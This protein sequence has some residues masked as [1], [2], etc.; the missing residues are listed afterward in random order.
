MKAS[1]PKQAPFRRST[2]LQHRA[3]TKSKSEK[4]GESLNDGLA[5]CLV[6][7]SRTMYD[8][9]YEEEVR[10]QAV[11][12]VSQVCSVVA[13]CLADTDGWQEVLPDAEM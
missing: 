12:S 10:K 11:M 4:A 6:G 2:P 8:S 13:V 3:N 1:P 7:F 5:I 9:E